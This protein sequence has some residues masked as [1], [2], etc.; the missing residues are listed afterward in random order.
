MVLL[1]NIFKNNYFWIIL[2]LIII[3]IP[4]G[5]STYFSGLPW[6]QSI[7]TIIVIIFFPILILFSKKLNF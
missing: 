7:E 1:N 3:T 6:S 5:S 4:N 2:L